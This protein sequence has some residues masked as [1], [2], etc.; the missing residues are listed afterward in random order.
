MT[1][2]DTMSE[3]RQRLFII[4]NPRIGR[5]KRADLLQICQLLYEGGAEVEMVIS[6]RRGEGAELARKAV[7]SGLFDAVIAAG[8][9]GTVHDVARGLLGSE[10]P[11]GIVPLG[12]ANVLAREIGMKPTPA[13]VARTLLFGPARAI[14]V[15]MAN[16]EPFLFVV[17]VGFDAAAVRHFETG[18]YRRLGMGGLAPP[19]L[20]ALAE[21]RKWPLSV[22]LD[23]ATHE[24]HWVIVTR[25]P[26]YAANILLCEDASLFSDTLCVV[27]FRG[28]RRA[29]LRQLAA[30]FT[31]LLPHDPGVSILHARHIRITGPADTPVQMDGESIGHLP[32]SLTTGEDRLRLIFG[33]RPLTRP[34]PARA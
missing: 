11:L 20:R 16:D 21:G 19:V 8:G 34:T 5:G 24:A 26:R 23:G 3:A 2:D 4:A 6:A 1:R 30:L 31:G 33:N 13:M 12:T 9:D 32:L 14:R 29:R 28:G 27:L 15:G 18:G 25:V 7:D 10:V 17:G 22:E